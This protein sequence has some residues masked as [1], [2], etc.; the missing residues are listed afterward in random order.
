VKTMAIVGAG[1]GLGMSLARRF[2]REAF[3][4]GLIA[5]N[6]QRLDAH[7][8][9]LKALGIEAVSASADARHPEELTAAIGKIQD[10]LGPVDVLECSPLVDMSSLQLV[11]EMTLDRLQDHFDLHVTGTVAAVNEVL[12]HMLSQ[13]DGGILITTGGTAQWPSATHGSGCIAV[14]ALR[15]YMLMLSDAVSHK[16]V[17]VGSISIARPD[18]RD[19]MADIYW[20]MFNQRDRVEVV[21]GD[22]EAMH[23][24]ELLVLR[25]QAQWFPVPKLLTPKDPSNEEDRRTLLLGLHQAKMMASMQGDDAATYEAWLDDLVRRHGGDPT[26]PRCGVPDRPRETIRV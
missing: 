10:T 1:P 3:R 13:G 9:E 5:R 2:G 23:G 17:F 7:V 20:Q 11:T 6:Q 19:E 4:I 14:G 22:P 15:H 26:A 18:G 16:G 8:A 12:P 21:A 24:F 25:D